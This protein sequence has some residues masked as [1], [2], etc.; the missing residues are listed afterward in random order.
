MKTLSFFVIVA[1]IVGLPVSGMAQSGNINFFVGSKTLD[2][3]WEPVDEH[4]EIGGLFDY[5]PPNWPVSLA[6][7]VLYSFGDEEQFGIKVENSMLELDVGAK[8][9][10]ENPS[11]INPFVA[12][13][14]A[15]VRAEAEGDFWDAFDL[16]DDTTGTGI[17]LSGGAYVTINNNLNLGLNARW[18]EV[19]SDWHNIDVELGGTRIGAFAGFHW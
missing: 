5:R 3:D 4:L 17:W 2:D 1:L 9:I 6:V 16:E 18:T 8:L 19:E 11:M 7:D 13:G 10:F 12:G 15:F 14:I